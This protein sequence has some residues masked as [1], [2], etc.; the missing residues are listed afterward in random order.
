[1]S[2]STAGKGPGIVLRTTNRSGTVRVSLARGRKKALLEV[3][4]ASG[5]CAEL[6]L[7]VA[8]VNTLAQALRRVSRALAAEA[9]RDETTQR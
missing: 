2:A 1:M 9:M 7:S 8:E 3:L 5:Q 4:D 6:G